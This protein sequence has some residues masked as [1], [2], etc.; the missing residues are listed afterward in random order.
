MTPPQN[1]HPAA[2][3]TES[4]FRFLA[5]PPWVFPRF[6][7]CHP[8]PPS[9]DRES[10]G[11]VGQPII[12]QPPLSGDGHG[13]P[14]KPTSSC[15]GNRKLVLVLGLPGP[16]TPQDSLFFSRVL[17]KVKPKTEGC[18]TFSI[19]KK[20][21]KSFLTKPLQSALGSLFLQPNCFKSGS[22]PLHPRPFFEY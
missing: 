13:T 21:A 18:G 7:V 1:Q 6:P 17:F 14:T 11:Q 4:W 20:T 9:F 3:A 15:G 8:S 10:H 12:T 2:A 16:P 19:H 22:N 5:N